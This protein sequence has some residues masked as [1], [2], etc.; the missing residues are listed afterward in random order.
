[1]ENDGIPGTW[2]TIL[3]PAMIA[4]QPTVSAPQLS[5]D[6]SV[7]AY[8]SALDGRTDLFTMDERGH[9]RQISVDHAI[10]SGSYAWTRDSAAFIFTSAT[11]GKLWTCP[12]SGGRARR[13]TRVEG[14]HHSP[15]VSPD[16]RYVAFLNL[17]PESVDL[18]VVSVDGFELR[19]IS[20][21]RDIPMSPFMVA[22]QSPTDL[23]RLSFQ[24]DAVGPKR[25]H[26]RGRFQRRCA[27]NLQGRAQSRV[28]AG[29]VLSRR[30]THRLCLRSEWVA[31]RHRNECRWRQR[32]DSPLRRLGAW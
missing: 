3:T 11:D 4:R 20:R 31:Q 23:A 6:G 1:M 16:G 28:C 9:S 10:G 7:L 27:A 30:H 5:P 21:G 17:C 2:S 24:P 13:L 19:Q 15:R 14:T 18:I 32:D 25:N 22:Q 12:A 29:G 8:L 26:D